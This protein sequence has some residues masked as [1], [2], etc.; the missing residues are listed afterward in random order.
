MSDFRDEAIMV[1]NEEIDSV[2]SD[3]IDCTP[4]V[5]TLTDTPTKKIELNH[6]NI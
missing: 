5:V 1:F 2:I 3:F 6:C 4:I